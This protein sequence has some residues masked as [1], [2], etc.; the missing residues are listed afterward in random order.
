MKIAIAHDYIISRGGAERVALAMAQ[1]L[2]ADVWTTNYEPDRT[3]DEFR[4][5]NVFSNPLLSEKSPLLQ[6]AAI[7]KFRSMDLSGYDIII[8]SGNW[9]KQVGM[10]KNNHPQIHYEYTPPRAFYDL[11]V[12]IKKRLPLV[13]RKFFSAWVRY[14][15][16]ADIDATKKIEKML[17]LSEVVRQRIW[18]CYGRD[19]DIVYPSVD[20]EKY[21]YRK[22]GD[23]FLSV[24]RIEPEKRVDM[25]LEIFRKLP[26]E[27]LVIVG[28]PGKNSSDYFNALKK[29]APKNVEFAGSI[30]DKQLLELYAKCRAT[31]QT[32]VN[33]DFGLIPVE[34]MAAGKPALA[35]NEGGF[36]ETIIN[37]KTGFLVKEPYVK[38]FAKAIKSL[39]KYGITRKSCRKRAEFFSRKNFMKG[40]RKA[41]EEVA[42]KRPV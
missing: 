30:S 28:S 37:G 15:K 27:K 35:V 29:K 38:N 22:S 34:G 41:I 2:K 18:K 19:S 33:E 13:Q 21:Y 25:Q 36:A 5:I 8:S 11:Y 42:E 1:D 9:A 7:S 6:T 31:I 17:T 10:K 23:F 39:G 40:I 20:L 24:Q 14:A 32:S 16:K 12:P 3:F 4:K 26:N